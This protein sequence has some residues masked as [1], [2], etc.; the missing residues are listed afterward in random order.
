MLVVADA[1]PLHYLILIE[2][3]A[4][5][6]SLYGSIVVPAV[7]LAELHRPQAP[8]AV[9]TWLAHM[10]AWLDVRQPRPRLSVELPHLGA[11]ERDAILLAQELQADLI[12]LDDQKGRQAAQQR[13]LTVMGTLGV[14]ERAA[15]SGLLDLPQAIARLQASNFRIHRDIIQ[16]LLERDT[17][18][19][20]PLPGI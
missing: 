11:G 1:S 3:I 13:A 6:P 15:I 7:V 17:A 10:P 12:L 19:R 18:R 9:R 4:V 14:L 2:Q 8:Q 5:L 16:E 20:R